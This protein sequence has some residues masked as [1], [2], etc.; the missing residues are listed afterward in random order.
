MPHRG[1]SKQT[2]WLSTT[3]EPAP[4]PDV[5]QGQPIDSA[6]QSL[7][8]VRNESSTPP[9]CVEFQV[10]VQPLT[11][12]VDTGAAV[13]LAPESAVESLLPSSE[14]GTAVRQSSM[15]SEPTTT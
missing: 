1:P 10:N 4:F 13:S 12:E 7:F 9:Y 11:M 14:L 3:T 6:E 15:A 8:I 5:S 2:K